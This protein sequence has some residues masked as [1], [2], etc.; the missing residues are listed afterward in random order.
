M[1]GNQPAALP[2][3]VVPLLAVACGLLIAN[4]YFVQPIADLVAADFRMPRHS[5]GVGLP[6]PTKSALGFCE[7]S[8]PRAGKAFLR[9]KEA[10]SESRMSQRRMNFT[11]SSK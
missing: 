4:L 10:A 3:W 7:R 2:P 1:D 8:H 11:G 6:R 5:G 9:L